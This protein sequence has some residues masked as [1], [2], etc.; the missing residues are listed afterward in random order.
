MTQAAIPPPH[1]ALTEANP[2]PSGKLQKQTPVLRTNPHVEVEVKPL[3]PRGSVANVEDP[4]PSHPLYELQIKST[5]STRQTL[6]LYKRSLRAPTKEKALALIAVDF[7]G[8]NT[9]E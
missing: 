8:K 2:S 9:Q 1:L 3:K 5:Q 6:C 4:K 7:R